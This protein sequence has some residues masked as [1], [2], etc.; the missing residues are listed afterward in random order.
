MSEDTLLYDKI[1]TNRI[2]IFIINNSK[3]I[4]LPTGIIFKY[5]YA[6]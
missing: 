4:H 1:F 3:F 5:E 2:K 6:F